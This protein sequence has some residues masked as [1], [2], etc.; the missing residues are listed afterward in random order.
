M[1]TTNLTTFVTVMNTGS[2]SGAAEKLFI[3]Q[4]AVSK[5]IKNQR[6]HDHRA[7][8]TSINAKYLIIEKQQENRKAIVFDPI[9]YRAKAV[10]D[11]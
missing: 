4:P 1:N 9:G 3:T 8:D 11:F 2:I 6:G 5:R 7:N 10:H